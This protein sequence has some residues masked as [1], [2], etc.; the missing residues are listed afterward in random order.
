VGGDPDYA[1]RQA[2]ARKDSFAKERCLA[3]GFD[4]IPLA[5]DTFGGLGADASRAIGVAVAR[6]R[7]YRGSALSDRSAS[8]LCLRQRLQVA[9]VRGVARQLL[10][11]VRG[12][13]DD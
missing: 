4:F 1:V 7:I 2:E 12:G 3:R 9:A 10:R 8:R 13:E 5:M 11:R 6:A